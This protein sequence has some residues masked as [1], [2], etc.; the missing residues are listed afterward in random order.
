MSVFGG[1]SRLSGMSVAS[2]SAPGA[3]TILTPSALEFVHLLHSVFDSERKILLRARD[4]RATHISQGQMPTFLE[5]TQEVRASAWTVAPAPT[6]LQKRR[7]EI[8]GPAEPKMMINALNS[9]AD[10]FMADL[11][12]ALS[13]T[14]IN[15]IAGQVALRSAVRQTLQFSSSE[16]RTYE[17]NP[18]TATLLVRPRGWHLP[19]DHV[20][21]QGEAV[22]ASL[23]DFGLYFFHNAAE[24]VARKT[25]PYFYLPKLE[26]H[27]EARLWNDVFC[28]AQKQL[29]LPRGT[30]RATVLIETLP[31]AFE[32]DEI[33]FELREHAS[34]LNAGRWD[35]LFSMLKKLGAVTETVFPDRSALTMGVPFMESYAKLLVRTCHRRGAY[36]IGGMSAFIPSRKDQ[37]VNERAIAKVF[38]DK[39]REARLGFDGAWVAHPDLVPVAKDAFTAVMGG[40]PHQLHVVPE[41]EPVNAKSLLPAPI[42]GCEVTESGIRTNVSVALRYLAAWLAG[43]GA[44]AID[45]LMEDAATAEIS[46]AQLWQW[47]RKDVLDASRFERMLSEEVHKMPLESR[48]LAE[49]SASLLS[50]LVLSPRFETFLTIPAYRI[51]QT[52]SNH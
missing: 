22:S 30:I 35:Y 25:A 36:A 37:A 12:D 41:G 45:H 19:E 16:G 10:A 43:Q 28:F 50:A 4:E 14:W 11:E 8:T 21:A 24:L 51:L 32:M 1:G 40:A 18:K 42:P 34:G 27:L 33:L 39:S 20:R 2:S 48:A 3:E 7:V 23:F 52:H 47:V 17:L 9:G 46:R 38:E 31:A 29:G 44:V 26:S 49:A 6:D 13:P 5:S 15:I